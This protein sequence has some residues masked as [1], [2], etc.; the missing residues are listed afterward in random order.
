MV[1][2]IEKGQVCNVFFAIDTLFSRLRTRLIVVREMLFRCD[3]GVAHLFP[4][5]AGSGDDVGG[6]ARAEVGNE[7]RWHRNCERYIP[8][9]NQ[10]L[11]GIQSVEVKVLDANNLNAVHLR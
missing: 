6:G 1:S 10:V 4:M 5:C 9:P 11:D 7:W 3:S 2:R 8:S